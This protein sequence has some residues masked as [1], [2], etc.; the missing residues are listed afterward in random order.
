MIRWCVLF[1]LMLATSAAAQIVPEPAAENPRLQRVVW[2]ADTAILLTA[3]PA[4]GLTVLLEPGEQIQRVVV[5]ADRVFDVRVSAER[6]SFLVLPLVEGAAASMVVNT[7]RRNYNFDLRT[8]EGLM[9]ALLVQF[10][11]GAM[12]QPVRVLAISNPVPEA[13]W[14]YRLRGDRTVRPQA[15]SD[16]GQRTRISFAPDQALP[17]I[18]AIGP[19]GD[20]Q[21]V[22]GYMRDGV[23]EIDRVWQQ[24]VFRIDK[25]KAT[26]ERASQPENRD[27]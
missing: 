20:E 13:I 15:I 7:D 17:A 11:Y 19:T 10:E 24:L 8:G 21:V 1:A 18:F 26:A 3:L 4:I 27:G 14:A 22:D 5:G 6:D 12:P 2:Q 16:D 23:F 25:E 9:A